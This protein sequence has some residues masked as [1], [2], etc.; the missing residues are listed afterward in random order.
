MSS[1]IQIGAGYCL[2]N[3][4]AG[5]LAINP[6]PLRALTIQDAEL[7]ISG[8]IESL[9]GQFQFPDDTAVTDKKG[10]GK[11]TMGRKDLS[12]LNQIFFADIAAVG[13]TSV[14]PVE[15]HVAAATI[16]VTPPGS[17]TFFADLGVY[18]G[19]NINHSFQRIATG[20]PTAGQY[21]VSGGTYT[22]ASA[23]VGLDVLI[24]YAYTQPTTGT[25][26]QVNNQNIGYGPQV[27]I[28][29]VD[30]YQPVNIGTVLLPVFVYSTIKVYAAKISK[31][32]LGNKRANY[33][34]PEVNYEYF[35]ANNGRVLDMFSNV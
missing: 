34:M 26:F 23:D 35:Q 19:A 22:F 16:S 25:I 33:S 29:M 30:T 1:Y 24:S 7:D 10:S 20:S 5:N 11:I 31:V 18:Y 12:L 6:T 28:Y 13:G 3:P 8:T 4:T 15:K 17:G 9:K 21:S 2:F 27:E 14:S 32:T